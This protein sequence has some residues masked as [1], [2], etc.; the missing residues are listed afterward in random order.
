MYS[1]LKSHGQPLDAFIFI[2]ADFTVVITVSYCRC[3][4]YIETTKLRIELNLITSFDILF[5]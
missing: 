3:G 5:V 2:K 1:M 4:C